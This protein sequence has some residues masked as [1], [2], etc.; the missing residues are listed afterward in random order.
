[1]VNQDESTV[2]WSELAAHHILFAHPICPLLWT[3]GLANI[4]DQLAMNRATA[5]FRLD[6]VTSVFELPAASDCF[7][8]SHFRREPG[9]NSARKALAFSYPLLCE[10]AAHRAL[11]TLISVNWSVDEL[12]GTN[13]QPPA[14][15]ISCAA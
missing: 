9:V 11:P 12:L 15:T 2:F 3:A 1:M 7:Q 8:R 4:F 10:L 5:L 13:R 14:V 6:H